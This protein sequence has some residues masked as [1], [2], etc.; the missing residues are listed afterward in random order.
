MG[1]LYVVGTPI[2]N[3]EDITL[4][5]LRV[6]REVD[7]IAAED[8][9]TTAKLL[10]RY[11]ISTPMV[12]YFEHNE[13]M[14]IEYLLELLSEKDVALVSEAGMPG[15]S[16]PGYRLIRAAIEADIR[17][18]PIPGPSALIAALAVSGLPTDSF[19]YL[20]FLPRRRSARKRT[21][22]ALVLE[23]RTLVAFES[24]HRLLRSLA[25]I[26]NVLG[27]RRIVVAREVTKLHEEYLR[28]KISEIIAHF[29]QHHPRGECTLV[30]AGAEK[31]T[32]CW[33]E[34]AVKTALKRFLG[35]GVSRKVAIRRIAAESGWP[36]RE[37]YRLSIENEDSDT[38]PVD[39]IS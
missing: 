30:I 24:P 21:L 17:V 18:V 14:R 29:Q 16:D 15:I 31:A 27:D 10:A 11:E 33:D 25:D 2:G 4:R 20:G 6:L 3:M 39:A 28:G 34:E 1:T 35:G 36:K 5:A 37:V 22:E 19:I 13:A 23:Q 7:L 8:T 38:Y 32:G 12:S 26:R 9:R